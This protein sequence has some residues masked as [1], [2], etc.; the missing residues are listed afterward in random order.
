MADNII[1]TQ[2]STGPSVAADD[3]S[4]VLYQRIK[5]A[6]GVDGSATDATSTTPFPVYLATVANTQPVSG[7][8]TANAGSGTFAISAASLPLPSGAATSAKQ[9]ALGTAGSASTD[10]LTVQGVASMTA[11]KVDG[12]GVTQPVSGT[13]SAAQSGTWNVA[14]VTNLS[15]FGGAAINL[16]AGA[17]STGTLRTTQASDSPLVTATGAV[18]D[19][20]WAS[21][22]GSVVALLKTIAGAAIDTTTASPVKIDQTTPGTTDAVS[23]AHVG[24]TAVASGNGT[25][26]AGCQ[27][28]TIAS[29]NTAFTVN[30]TSTPA[31]TAHALIA[32]PSTYRLLS[33][34]ASTNA[35]NIKS[36]A[37]TVKGIQGFNAKAS[38]VYLKLYNKAS[39]P[40]VGT[41]TPVKTIY[42][43]ATAAFAFDF[44]TGVAFATGISIALTGVGTDAD[45]TALVA[46]D[47]LALNVDYH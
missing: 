19:T 45:T 26:S 32:A 18:A 41:D 11:L 47:V 10:V 8:V 35:A 39:S 30:A 7:T 23:I 44:G 3:V 13:V 15:Q 12:S 25:A 9:P 31:S 37:G 4:G 20:A 29:D 43:P 28:I 14:T 33:A 5:V 38:A 22:S 36:S 16:G 1:V 40:T 46:A 2:A 17:V 27:R 6:H 42:L 34:A 21:G 24:S